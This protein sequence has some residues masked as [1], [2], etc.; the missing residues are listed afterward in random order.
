MNFSASK[1]MFQIFLQNIAILIFFVA[2]YSNQNNTFLYHIVLLHNFMKYFPS[3]R[4]YEK[5]NTCLIILICYL[6]VHKKWC[7][8]NL[9]EKRIMLEIGD[10]NVSRNMTL[11]N[12]FLLLKDLRPYSWVLFSL[13]DSRNTCFLLKYDSRKL[14]FELNPVIVSY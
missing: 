2:H 12:N 5:V 4:V 9:T 3:A 14:Y 11:S 8:Q 7:L 10:K 1:M 13:Y 6:Q